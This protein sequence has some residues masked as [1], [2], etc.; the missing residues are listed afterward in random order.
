[1]SNVRNCYVADVNISSSGDNTIV[2]A[3]SSA[4]VRVWKI[5]LQATGGQNNV[6][7][8]K[9]STAFNA[10]AYV[11]PSNSTFFEQDDGVAVFDCPINSAF[12]INLS[13]ATEVM[14]QVYYT[15]G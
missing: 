9:G 14:G 13:A 11:I 6:I 3:D 1:M 8:K 15:K 2:A 5:S 7:F 10:S 12:V 4:P